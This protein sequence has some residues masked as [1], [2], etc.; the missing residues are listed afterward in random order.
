VDGLI[1]KLR[2]WVDVQELF[3]SFV[4][5]LPDLFAAILVLV[6]FHFLYRVTRPPLEMALQRTRLHEKLVH[7]LVRSIYRYA[8]LI[9]SVV[10]ALD[11]LG[12]NVGAAL[13]GIGVV[14]I[15]IG[16]AAKDSLANI[17]AGFTIF[18]DKPFAVGSWI[19]VE[20]EFGQVADITLR[21][22][23]IRTKRNTWVVIPN[24]RIIDS[25][26]EDYTKQGEVRVDATI[27]IAYKESVR[28]AREVLLAAV[29][30]LDGVRREPAPDVVVDA[31]ADSSVNLH[32]RVWI[33][34]A[35]QIPPVTN[36]VL[37]AGKAAL[38]EAGIE[39]PFPHLQ[40]FFD[41]VRPPVWKGLSRLGV[42][43]S[44]GG[45]STD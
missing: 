8:V 29:A 30:D 23:R 41:D 34:D 11:Q 4:A 31:L 20:D 19:H 16:F 18:L 1:E 21:T 38:D 40:L 42:A 39:I 17:I 2:G 14:G 36:A 6:A 32:V 5:F 25:V 45:E 9:F 15:A 26:L 33:D 12:V 10:M 7:L 37:E 13:A 35:G 27:G 44:S 43:A 3:T 28:Q 24:Q 22:T